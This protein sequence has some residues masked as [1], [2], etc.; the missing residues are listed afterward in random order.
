MAQNTEN[1]ILPFFFFSW[2]KN[3]FYLSHLIPEGIFLQFIIFTNQFVSCWNLEALAKLITKVV[4]KKRQ[5]K[6]P[7]SVQSTWSAKEMG[8]GILTALFVSSFTSLCSIERPFPLLFIFSTCHLPS[9]FT[10]IILSSSQNNSAS[11]V[12]PAFS[13]LSPVFPYSDFFV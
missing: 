13:P 5:M 6:I 7:T 10:N 3:S 2:Y 12:V 9:I 4:K 8:K 11:Q 1:Q